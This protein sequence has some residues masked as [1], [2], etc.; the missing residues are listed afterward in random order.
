MCR[1]NILRF[2]CPIFFLS[3]SFLTNGFMNLN[4]LYSKPYAI[5]ENIVKNSLPGKKPLS[6]SKTPIEQV[7]FGVRLT[8]FEEHVKEKKIKEVI[9]H[10]LRAKMLS[11]NHFY[12]KK[13]HIET[14][15]LEWNEQNKYY[16]LKVVVFKRLGKNGL[17]EEH[18][19]SLKLK[20]HL[21]GQASPY[22][23]ASFAKAVFKS[24]TGQVKAT[25]IAG[26]KPAPNKS[27]QKRIAIKKL[28][29]DSQN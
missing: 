16:S 23:F 5:N 22:L 6:L 20:G 14:I 17:V 25:L 8:I 7:R 3:L 2:I 24:K 29:E 11:P 10:T 1:L 28:K 18:L 9:Q 26:Y 12:I 19:G 15:P 13:Y 21:K 4:E 27:S